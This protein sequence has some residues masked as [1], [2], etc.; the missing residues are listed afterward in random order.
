MGKGR[1]VGK[2]ADID[3]E[4]F[5][6]MLNVNAFNTILKDLSMRGWGHYRPFHWL[7]LTF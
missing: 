2:R 5:S 1:D 3:L 6:V 4:W 7:A